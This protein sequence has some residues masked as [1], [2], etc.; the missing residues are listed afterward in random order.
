MKFLNF[1]V[2]TLLSTDPGI[3]AAGTIY[4]NSTAGLKWYDTAWHTTMDLESAQTVSGTKTFNFLT[5]ASVTLTG[6]S[7]LTP[8]ADPSPSYTTGMFYLNTSGQLRWFGGNRMS[9][10]MDLESTQNVTGPKYFVAQVTVQDTFIHNGAGVANFNGSDLQFAGISIGR[11]AQPA[12]AGYAEITSNTTVNAT[13]TV[14]D[15]PGLAVT[16][17]VP[18][19]RRLKIT[20]N[21]QVTSS[22]ANDRAI[23][24]IRE[25]ST[26][27]MTKQTYPITAA[28]SA[29]EFSMHAVVNGPSAGTHTYKVGVVRFGAT[30]GNVNL[31]ANSSAP[32][33]II[34]EDIGAA[35]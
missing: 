6:M 7:Y 30:G 12:G 35:T 33:S 23:V 31:V 11:G 26:N 24:N 27:L 15:V 32:C 5:A 8:I 18:A 21:C 22:V 20:V 28:G 10:A 14:V 16:V 1:P 29:F 17:A 25:G 19:N 9:T 4:L 13:T 3:P 2:L 34:V